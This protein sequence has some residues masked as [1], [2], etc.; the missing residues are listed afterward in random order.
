M[1]F[2]DLTTPL[3]GIITTRQGV[4]NEGTKMTDDHDKFI[5]GDNPSTS[6]SKA[7]RTSE[8]DIPKHDL[9]KDTPGR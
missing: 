3:S 6:L 9:N 1:R 2:S 4:T 8:F 7:I 5:G